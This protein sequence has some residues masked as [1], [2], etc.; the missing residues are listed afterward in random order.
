MI[1]TLKAFCNFY[2]YSVGD[3]S[4]A[5]IAPVVKLI[6]GLEKIDMVERQDGNL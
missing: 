4:V 6:A 2:H 3:L 5:V 1:K